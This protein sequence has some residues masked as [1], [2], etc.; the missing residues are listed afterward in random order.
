MAKGTY[1]IRIKV[2]PEGFQL[3]DGAAGDLRRME[4]AAGGV[5]NRFAQMNRHVI[6]IASGVERLGR[7][8]MLLG[9]AGV[10]GF[11]A[12]AY[13]GIKYNATV[14]E[15]TAKLSNFITTQRGVAE[16]FRWAQAAV[17]GTPLMTKEM[18][19]T[20]TILETYGNSYKKWGGVV[21]D[22]AAAVKNPGESLTGTMDQIA[23]ALGRMKMGESGIAARSLRR[24]GINVYDAGLNFDKTGH[25][26]DDTEVALD[27]LNKYMTTKFGGGMERLGKTWGGLWLAM[28]GQVVRNLGE[29][30]AP[31]FRIL[32]ARLVTIVNFLRSPAGK[33]AMQK[34]GRVLQETFTEAIRMADAF[35]RHVFPVF[36]KA[37]KWFSELSAR[38]R[39]WTVLFPVIAGAVLILV[40]KIIRL[41]VAI[42]VYAARM[43]Q[44]T[45]ARQALTAAEVRGAAAANA[46]AAA[47]TK[48]GVA[49]KGAVGG[50]KSLAGA[51]MNA[52]P[53]L[54]LGW[55]AVK[56]KPGE[57]VIMGKS[58]KEA[59]TKGREAG[60][61]Y[62]SA[63]GVMAE[64]AKAH[65]GTKFAKTYK[66]TGRPN[67][68]VQPPL[69]HTPR[70]HPLGST[71]WGATPFP[72]WEAEGG[73]GDMGGLG[74]GGDGGGGGAGGG[75]VGTRGRG[76]TTIYQTIERVNITANKIDEKSLLSATRKLVVTEV[77]S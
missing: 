43:V 26:I 14:E 59:L 54:A 8:M 53:W 41:Y 12:V 60:E 19:N 21:A 30:L 65:P 68:G 56:S 15:M 4:A 58:E 74:G 40:A 9:T 25:L 16:A 20:I 35:R 61:K 42:R 32:K 37:A 73:G 23:E 18:V 51:I 67:F 52:A 46:S 39:V 72:Q 48:A 1:E 47:T 27:K 2:T 49:A 38:G 3:I 10:A 7:R 50:F 66:P 28:K 55:F 24:M 71:P 70:A 34:W 13:A 69:T 63:E 31:T 5:D 64:W 57:G 17:L 62:K 22:T 44:A 11:G 29:A 33:E 75:G 45:A 6:G 36:M 77:P 76:G